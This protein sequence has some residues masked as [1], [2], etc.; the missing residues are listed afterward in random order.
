LI[1]AGVCLLVKVRIVSQDQVMPFP[2]FLR[3]VDC[4]VVRVRLPPSAPV[5]ISQLS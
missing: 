3:S 5:I 1:L 4:K 2:T